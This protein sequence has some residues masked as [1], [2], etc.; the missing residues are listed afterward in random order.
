MLNGIKQIFGK[1]MARILKDKK[2]VFSV[3][4]LPVIIMVALL[5][6]INSLAGQMQSDIEEH[7]P[8]VWMQNEPDSFEAFLESA[9][10]EYDVR[11]V[12]SDSDRTKAED[13][14]LNGEADLLIEFPADFDELVAGFQEGDQVPQVKT[15]YNPSENYSPRHTRKSPWACWNPTARPCWQGGWATRMPSRYLRSILTMTRW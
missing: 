2:M 14:I 12:A 1:E 3:F 6:I 5:T 4:L 9:G 11:T 8:I 7:T 15:Y 10:M 13:Q